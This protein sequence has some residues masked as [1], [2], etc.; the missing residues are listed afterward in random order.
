M[1]LINM[2]DYLYNFAASGL[3]G[4]AL[5]LILSLLRKKYWSII[6][7][8]VITTILAGAATVFELLDV[9]I[10]MGF[11]VLLMVLLIRLLYS[12]SL[13]ESLFDSV[14]SMMIAVTV[15][16]LTTALL[17]YIDPQFVSNK[18]GLLI[19]LIILDLFYI[20]IIKLNAGKKWIS[21]RYEAYQESIW[22]ICLN[23]VF[24]Q[25]AELY[26]WN[27]T[28]TMSV[29]IVILVCAAV[30]SNVA[31]AFRIVKYNQQKEQLKKQSELMELK[32]TFL[33]QMAAE[34]HDFAKHL[35]AM[36][37]ILREED[38]FGKLKTI[39]SYLE[40]L[41]ASQDSKK[42]AV[43]MGDGVLSA[44]LHERQKIAAEQNIS[45]SV[46]VK[47]DIRA[48]P[49]GQKE[50]V[51]IVSN[52][53]DNAFEAVEQIKTGPRKI[54]FETGELHGTSFLQTINSV[55]VQ[56]IMPGQMLKRGTSTKEGTLRGYG[57]FNV[58]Q[59]TEKYNG[60]MKIQVN[61]EIIVIKIL[62][63]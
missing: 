32:E 9:D 8:L 58:K 22:I 19:Y 10:N 47:K 18:A 35:R 63:H 11:S 21:K 33:Q 57:L 28:N 16:M 36:R 45:F 30:V 49:F 2:K 3:E 40:E 24:I 6:K 60:K 31:L 38:D 52:L 46:L 39:E 37:A 27:N 41:I 20:L 48:F 59:I 62:F 4:I 15:E 17:C 55:P 34:Q 51:E 50:M 5:C 7:F 29:S 23:F 1:N 53:L 13:L 42:R 14:C 44:I 12:G 26:N 61:D 56:S 54:L 43:Y 25:L